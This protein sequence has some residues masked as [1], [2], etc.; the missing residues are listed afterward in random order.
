MKK[1]LLFLSTAIVVLSCNQNTKTTQSGP[2]EAHSETKNTV[3]FDWLTGKWKRSN[4][5]AGKE[6]FENWNKISPTEYSGIGFTLQKG[7]TI[8]K[9]IMKIINSN[10]K[11]TLLV[12][13]PKEK[14][15]IKFKMTELKSN[16]FICINDSLD[17]PKQIQYSSEGKK[18]KAIISNEKMKIPFEFEQAK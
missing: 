8:S 1:S 13:T 6:T 7:D 11:W 9:E 5:K 12:K 4:E 2:S 15:F 18:L 10:G 16:E 17:F 14:Q 3:N